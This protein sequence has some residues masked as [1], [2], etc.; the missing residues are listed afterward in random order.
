ME[1]V[2][3]ITKKPRI[4]VKIQYDILLK[5]CK[6]CKFQEHDEQDCRILLPELRI[7]T[8]IIDEKRNEKQIIVKNKEP[9]VE[10]NKK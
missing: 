1:I 2:N 7:T 4:E 6:N 8:E 3:P 10:K 5:Y 9:G